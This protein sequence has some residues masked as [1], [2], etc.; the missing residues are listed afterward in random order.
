[1]VPAPSTFRFES[2]GETPNNATLPLLLY[3]EVVPADAAG[4][5]AG[6]FE[7]TFAAH[8]WTQAWRNG[9]HPFLHFHTA[10]HEVLGI[11]A[12]RASV[13]FGGRAGVTLDVAAGDVVVLPAGTGHRRLDASRDLLVVGAYPANGRFDQRRPGEVDIDTACRAVAAVPLP[14]MD[15]IAGA[16]GPLTTLWRQ[17]TSHRRS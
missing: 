15:P 14:E 11:A 13:Q 5:A 16:R 4:D 8:N 6:W 1:M 12:G 7:R 9:I 10:A 2:D 17:I 3:R